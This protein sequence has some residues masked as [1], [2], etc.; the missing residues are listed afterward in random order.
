[1]AES[2]TRQLGAI[3]QHLGG[4]S[5]IVSIS[6]S[7][8]DLDPLDILSSSNSSHKTYWQSGVAG[9]QVAAG[10]AI[11]RHETAGTYRFASAR[12]F[13]QQHSPIVLGNAKPRFFAQFSFFDRVGSDYPFPAAS[14]TLP[15]WTA[16]R[17][18]GRCTGITN[19]RI[20]SET[21]LDRLVER[22][23]Q[24]FLQFE[25]SPRK[26]FS[27]SGDRPLTFHP[28]ADA[29]AFRTAVRHVLDAIANEYLH[30]VVLARAIDAIA[31]HPWQPLD[32]L[33][34]LRQTYPDCYVFAVSG[35][36]GQTFLGASP[37]CLV[38][39]QGNLASVDALAGSAPRGANSVDD[40]ILGHQLLDSTKDRREHDWVVKAI[41]TRLSDLGLTPDVARAPALLQLASIQHLHTPI[42][43]VVPDSLHLL[44]L[45][46]ALHPTP[47]VAGAPAAAATQ[48]IQACEP[49]ERGLYAAPIGWMDDRGNGEMAVAIRSALLSDRRA[50]LYAG[51]GIVRGS[52]PDKE[53]HEIQ[54]KLQALVDALA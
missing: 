38:R 43:A 6:R 31:P 14:I 48:H 13:A 16:I 54:L 41:A 52:D 9:E 11:A 1:D 46:A 7:L 28:V 29:A 23:E 27:R 53:L 21:V 3:Q 45:T 39:R 8:P 49:F 44:D 17:S 24:Q 5:V 32:V 22:I 42:S 19:V 18:R 20:D 36:R 15:E 51:A 25:R 12:Q 30:K 40:D 50:R 37:E 26:S 47:A 34:Q 2:L 4:R 35:D 10:G 33:R